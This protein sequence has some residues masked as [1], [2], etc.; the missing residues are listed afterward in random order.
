MEN[1]LDIVKEF[2]GKKLEIDPST[3]LPESTL[4][5]VGMDS[6]D[7]FDVIFEAEDRFGIKVPNEQVDVN[8]I[9][10]MVNLLNKLIQEKATAAK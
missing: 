7:T 8:T 9:Q 4:A 5:E 10:D 2:I 1:T 6:L 3:I